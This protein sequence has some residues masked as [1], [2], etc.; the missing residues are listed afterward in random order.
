MASNPRFAANNSNR[1]ASREARERIAA[2][3]QNLPNGSLLRPLGDGEGAG[4]R[5]LNRS[6]NNRAQGVGQQPVNPA[7]NAKDKYHAK[8][9]QRRTQGG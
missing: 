9:D 5:Y 3:R 4:S 6:M 7:L 8:L 2:R 1:D